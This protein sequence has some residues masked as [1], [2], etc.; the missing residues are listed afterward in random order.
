LSKELLAE[1]ARKLADLSK[2]GEQ[3]QESSGSRQT[4]DGRILQLQRAVGNHRVAELI[5]SGQVTRDGRLLPIRTKL[6]VGAPNNSCEREAERVSR[7]VASIPDA[8][9]SSA[10]SEQNDRDAGSAVAPARTASI[11]PWESEEETHAEARAGEVSLRRQASEDGGN[12]VDAGSAIE[13]QL[14]ANKGGGSPLPSSVRTYMEPRFGLDFGHVRIHTGAGA[15]SLNEAVGAKAFT[16]G[17]EI[18][19]GAS[20]SPDQLELTAHELAH[21]VQ[22]GGGSPL[23]PLQRKAEKDE[24]EKECC[25]ECAANQAGALQRSTS[26]VA[27][28]SP[29]SFLQAGNAR[30]SPS[31]TARK[32]AAMQPESAAPAGAAFDTLT[33]SHRTS[34]SGGALAGHA[35]SIQR[36][37]YN[38]DIPF[39]D[40]QFDPSLEGL[41]T[42]GNVVKDTAVGALDWIVDEIKS[43]VSSGIDWLNDKWNSLEEFASSAF[44]S[45]KSVFTDIVGLLKNPLSLL[46]DGLMGLDAQALSKA[47]ATFSGLITKVGNEFKAMT[48]GLLDQVN[49]VWNGINGFA[50]SL[51]NRVS[52]LTENFLFKKLPDALQRIAFAV[53]DQLNSLWKSINDGWTKLFNT[54]KTWVD[55]AIDTVFSFVRKVGSFGINIVIAGIVEFGHLVLFLKDLFSNPRKYADLLAQRSVKAFDGVE[56]RFAGLI[57]QYFGAAKTAAPVAAAGAKVQRAP[58]STAPA[59]AKTSASWSEIGTGV[60]EMMKKKWNEFKSNPLSIVTGLLMDM[61]LP[62]VGNVK[63]II[64]LFQDIKKVVTGPLSAGSLEEL[65][66]SI[67]QILDI[68]ILIYQTVVSI[69]MRTLMVPLIVATFI[70]HPLVKAIAAAVGEALLAAFVDAEVTNVEHKLLLLKTGATVESQKEEAYNRI[71]DSLIAGAMTLVIVIV[72][73]IL[74]FIANVMKGIFNFVKGKIFRIGESTAVT[75]EVPKEAPK[76]EAPKGD[77]RG[78]VPD[79]APED[80]AAKAPIE[81]GGEAEVTKDGRCLICTSPCEL[82]DQLKTDF[83]DVLRDPDCETAKSKLDSATKETDPTAQ[84]TRAAE[85]KADL[86]SLRKVLEWEKDGK[87]K[88]DLSRLKSDLGSS[89]PGTRAGARAE[90]ME[91]ESEIKAGKIPEVRGAQA[92]PDQPDYEVKAR[93]EPFTS[94]K[95]AQNWFNDRIKAANDQLGKAGG[96]GRVVINLGD[97]TAIGSETIGKDMARG[98]IKSALSKGA[99]GTAITEVVV[100]DGNGIVIYQGLG[101]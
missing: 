48:S 34:I 2:S 14:N 47:W 9:V 99:R 69:L 84:A 4:A 64:K 89:N 29:E 67:L 3:L 59:E 94:E 79:P 90:L 96:K 98:L 12:G 77:D 17:S 45:A 75:G 66:T 25:P 62:I 71:A 10:S 36:D 72:M 30:R 80:I 55:K 46:A 73:L 100:K 13:S 33:D 37:W 101:E 32:A 8:E 85:L 78:L 1:P 76:A 83:A 52:S 5:S 6:R 82:L 56:N 7:Q 27:V 11:R 91:L 57:G 97:N 65:W 35:P 61:V 49:K 26:D 44:D 31:A 22:Q 63:D 50:T 70:P 21:V 41:K 54:I 86:E 43:L 23:P 68:P 38:F 60:L 24:E 20:H 19:Y 42:A 39:T 92:G 51:L 40:Y 15:A 81:G 88:G 93:S 87:L 95:N 28:P 16:Y 58:V 53:I 74:H 18:Y